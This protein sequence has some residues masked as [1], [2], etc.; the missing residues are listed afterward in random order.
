M[1]TESSEISRESDVIAKYTMV[2]YGWN[3]ANENSH[4][5]SS[6]KIQIH[7]KLNMLVDLYCQ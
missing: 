4:L 1:Q 2:R 7:A 3:R 5:P 6:N